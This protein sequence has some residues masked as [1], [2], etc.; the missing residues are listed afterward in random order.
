M[1]YSVAITGMA[2]HGDILIV[3]CLEHQSRRALRESAAHQIVQ[4]GTPPSKSGTVAHRAIN[5]HKLTLSNLDFVA[6]ILLRMFDQLWLGL[7]G[8]SLAYFFGYD[9]CTC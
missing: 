3:D 8:I 5:T 7:G 9:L 2:T 4:S 1:K 6:R